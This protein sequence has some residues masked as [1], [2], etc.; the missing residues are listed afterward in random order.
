MEKGLASWSQA[1][2]TKDAFAAE[3]R[4]GDLLLQGHVSNIP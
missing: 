4:K 1:K 3:T 2:G